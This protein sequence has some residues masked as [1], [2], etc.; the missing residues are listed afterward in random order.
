MEKLTLVFG[1]TFS[2]LIGLYLMGRVYSELLE[3]KIPKLLNLDEIRDNI[4]KSNGFWEFTIPFALVFG[5]VF[6]IIALSGFVS[7]AFTLKK[8][9]SMS[10][11]DLP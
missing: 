1:S 5:F 9:F 2:V 6:N 4:R 8:I 3:R 7:L 10:D 11:A